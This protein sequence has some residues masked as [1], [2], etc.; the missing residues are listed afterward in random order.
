MKILKVQQQG[1]GMRNILLILSFAFQSRFERSLNVD[2]IISISKLLE[3]IRITQNKD[4]YRYAVIIIY[5]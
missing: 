4:R 1:I 5:K 3:L 2:K